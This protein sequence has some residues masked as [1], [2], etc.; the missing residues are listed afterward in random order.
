M[1]DLKASE[2]AQLRQLLEGIKKQDLNI[3]DVHFVS[4]KEYEALAGYTK[5]Y[6]GV[7]AVV[8][9]TGGLRRVLVYIAGLFAA[10]MAIRN[11]GIEWL[12]NLLN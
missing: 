2:I 3:D 12:R 4:A 6:E 9:L 7:K 8:W 11:G 5:F 1:T 10:V